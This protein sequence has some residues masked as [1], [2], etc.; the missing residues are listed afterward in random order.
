MSGL[1][2]GLVASS[3]DESRQLADLL[4]EKGAKV[5]HN[6]RPEEISAEQ[7]TDESLH[8][9]LLNVDDDS[10]HDAIDNLLDE[11]EIPVYF[12]EPGTLEK[13]PHKEFWCEKL[14]LRL[15]EI[16]GIGEAEAQA[17]LAGLA[18]KNE[19]VAVQ[20]TSHLVANVDS[21]EALA[22]SQAEAAQELE[23]ETP[24]SKTLEELEGSTIGLPQNIAA[25]L[26]SELESLSPVL[27]VEEA[28]ELEEFE[29][30]DDSPLELELAQTVD[31]DSGLDSELNP[32]P[33]SELGLDINLDSSI[34]LNSSV[35]LDSG[36]ETELE[37]DSE[38]DLG[39]SSDLNQNSDLGEGI[40]LSDT[41]LGLEQSDEFDQ[42]SFDSSELDEEI[43]LNLTFTNEQEPS[44]DVGAE[45]G[46]EKQGLEQSIVQTPDSSDSLDI[47]SVEEKLSEKFELQLDAGASPPDNQVSEVA[48]DSLNDDPLANFDSELSLESVEEDK[49]IS[50]HAQFVI[51]EGED[52]LQ[53]EEGLAQDKLSA[54][55]K[56]EEFDTGGLSLEALP[57]DQPVSG[58]ASFAIDGDDEQAQDKE[59]EDALAEASGLESA[60]KVNDSEIDNG[61]SLELMDSDDQ[62]DWLDE[63]E[64]E[65]STEQNGESVTLNELETNLESQAVIEPEP[66]IEFDFD[67]EPIA[68]EDEEDGSKA[69]ESNGVSSEIAESENEGSEQAQDESLAKALDSSLSLESMEP[70]VLSEE[71]E[72]PAEN[73]D[74]KHVSP[75]E[76]EQQEVSLPA[77][78]FDRST[79]ELDDVTQ[80]SELDPALISEIARGAIGKESQSG[81]DSVSVTRA[82][83]PNQPEDFIAPDIFS[84]DS[85]DSNDSKE[86]AESAELPLHEPP[87][88]ADFEIP[89]LDETALDVEFEEKPEPIVQKKLVPLWVIGASLGGPAAVKRFLHCIPADINAS[90][91]IA[92][93]IDE[94]FLPVLAEILTSN[95]HF[96]V[97]VANGSCGVAAGNVYL[98]P[99]KGK[100]LCLQ[101][102]SM[103]VDHSQKW[104]APYSPCINDVIEAVGQVYGEQ[105]G[106]IIFSGM[107]DDGLLGAQKMRANGGIVWAQSADTCANPVYARGSHQSW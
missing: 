14:L 99:L 6:I 101:D 10:W 104:S 67:L 107:G 18:S 61:L 5:V 20:E 43:D 11:S 24:L 81:A 33:D 31:S 64:S 102:G 89:M 66:E 26:V 55:S 3:G 70:D 25:E 44:A 98:A 80:E 69:A 84:N 34:D 86:A 36:F 59:S 63:L 97:K 37:L 73:F 9:W 74:N 16:T 79:P 13:Q 28:V 46:L 30:V 49:P 45:A 58:R 95:S 41:D 48:D 88:E 40:E 106:A 50:G 92:Q 90:F 17:E 23:A 60:D 94:N 7:I 93:H 12:C 47:E 83:Q 8:V 100:L 82:P 91:V 77:E 65:S 4:E 1:K 53:E 72:R 51:D 35:D 21:K 15:Y 78:A 52:N 56:D 2:I 105:S 32:E 96:D 42:S 54:D 103:L 76:E 29:E 27:N 39:A 85:N 19:S 68:S 57:S 62:S 22:K 71:S 75:S 87:V 38:L